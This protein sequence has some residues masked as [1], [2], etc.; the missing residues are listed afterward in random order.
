M[1]IQID[2]LLI[3][4]IKGSAAHFRKFYT[5]SSSLSYTFPPRTT[6]TG[7]IA[8]MLGLPSERYTKNKKDI[9][10]DKFICNKC[11]IAVSI[12]TPVRKIMQTVN[13]VNTAIGG[14]PGGIKAVNLS[15]G[16]T[17]IPLEIVLPSGD[18][19]MVK[20]RIYFYHAEEIFYIFRETLEKGKFV[21]PPY[22]GISEFIAEVEFVDSIGQDKIIKVSDFS[23]PVEIATVINVE[24]IPKGALIFEPNSGVPLQYVKERMPLEFDSERKLKKTTSYLYEKNHN[25][26]K[27]NKINGNFY[28]INYQYHKENEIIENIV[29]MEG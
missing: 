19:N 22:L 24:Q 12:R 11:R 2:K 17:Q 1:E 13:Y 23:T 7:L 8:G 4:D 21:Y 25:K 15:G 20:Y 26:I 3:F 29:F 28:R 16:H 18:A 10:Y 9:Y 14:N 6:I 5:N 27:L